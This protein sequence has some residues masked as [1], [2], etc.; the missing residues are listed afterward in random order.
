M[1][2]VVV[3]LDDIFGLPVTLGAVG[4]RLSFANSSETV[5]DYRHHSYLDMYTDMIAMFF[6]IS[7]MISVS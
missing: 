5:S 2:R 4:V 1:A 6:V 7:V 3:A